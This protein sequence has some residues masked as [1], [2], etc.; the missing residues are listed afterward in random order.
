[1]EIKQVQDRKN[2]DSERFLSFYLQVQEKL[3]VQAE[4]GDKMEYQQFLWL[5][6]ESSDQLYDKKMC[7]ILNVLIKM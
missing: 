5:R 2:V 7:S 4:C 1:M 6:K 3:F